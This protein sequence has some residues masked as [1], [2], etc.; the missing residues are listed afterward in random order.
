MLGASALIS[1]VTTVLI[2]GVLLYESSSFFA[3]VRLDKFLLT[4]TW[5]PQYDP[6]QFGIWALVSATLVSTAIALVVALPIGTI[7]AF[8][9]VQARLLFPL[10]GLMRVALDLQTSSALFARIF[11]YLDLKPAIT[12]R[13]G[14]SELPTGT[15]VAGEPLLGRV[16][17][18]RV[19]FRYP[20]ADDDQRPTL[21]D[22]SF[23]IEPGQYAAF[24]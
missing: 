8:T 13:P 2:V 23:V 24:V 10:M 20:D 17:F 5:A 6:P 11:E 7:V 14:S 21:D 19:S 15:D 1:I 3:A 16:E 9:T 18:D 12:D 4:T 22:V